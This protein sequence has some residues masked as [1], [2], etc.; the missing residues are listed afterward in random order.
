MATGDASS[1]VRFGK[2]AS[3]PVDNRELFLSVFGGEV[4]TAFDNATVTLDKH[5]VKSVP[6]GAKSY[7]FP[8]TWKASAEYH[9]PGTE[10]LGNDLSTSEQIITVDDILVS[11]YAIADLDRIL[12]H[13]DMRSV[14]SAEMGRAL[15]KVFDKNVFRQL[16]LAANTAAASPF[17]GGTVTTDTGLAASGGVYSGIE[18]IEAI[19]TANIGLFNKDVPEDMPRYAAVSVEVFDAIKYAKDSSNNY[20]VL[21]RDFGHGGAGGIDARAEMMNIDGV[22]IVKSRNIPTTDESSDTSVYSKY[23]SDFQNTAVVMWCPQSVATVKMLDT[24][25][26][27]E[28]DV[29]RL[30][31]FLVSKMFVG[32]GTLRPEMAVVLKSA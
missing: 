19:R 3:S 8:K 5:F 20:L 11:H 28:R 4:L 14:I 24:S 9:T 32:H 30:E 27:T 6:G 12:S 18:Y 22:T 7:R 31:D 10:L 17:P 1:P 26:E 15:A 25:M 13:F 2:G 23:R 29:R 16:I 21:N